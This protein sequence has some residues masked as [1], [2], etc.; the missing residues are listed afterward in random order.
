M[1]CPAA[2]LKIFR[3]FHSNKSSATSR[4]LHSAGHVRRAGGVPAARDHV[5]A[6]G[7]RNAPF[8]VGSAG[9]GGRGG[10]GLCIQ[11]LLAISRNGPFE[12][13]LFGLH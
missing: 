2:P 11:Q 1:S 12:P 10:L 3:Q 13:V 6:L 7:L 8:M 9:A 5:A 4:G